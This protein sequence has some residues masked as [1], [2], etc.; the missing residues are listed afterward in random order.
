MDK[1]IQGHEQGKHW[2]LIPKSM[3]RRGTKTL[4]AIWSMQRKRRIET[5]EIY[6]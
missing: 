6:K 4:D 3:V 1:E 5:C 2:E